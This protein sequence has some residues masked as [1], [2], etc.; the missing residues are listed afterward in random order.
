MTDT[1]CNTHSEHV[2]RIDR[3]EED[4]QR[5]FTRFGELISLMYKIDKRLEG[6]F[7]KIS[8]I[9]FIM[10]LLMGVVVVFVEKM[11]K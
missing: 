4:I 9:A 11:F 5:L 7:G 3:A 8:G 1:P 6:L 2:V 10:S